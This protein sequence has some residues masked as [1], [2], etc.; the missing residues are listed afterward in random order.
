MKMKQLNRLMLGV[1]LLM[2]LYALAFS[3]GSTGADG[4]F[5]PTVTQQVDL[6]PSGIFNFTNVSIPAGV[7][8]TFKKNA[9]NTP[10]TIL[11]TGDVSIAGT[12]DIS[13]ATS[14][15]VGSNGGSVGDDGQ[16][17]K[18]GPGGFDGGR[19]GKPGV[20]PASSSDTATALLRSGGA[21]LGP[22]GGGLGFLAYSNSTWYAKLGAGGGY[23]ADP[24]AVSQC[25]GD[26]G[27]AYGSTLLLP[28]VGGSGGGGGAGGET[29]YGSG[30]GGGGGA[31]LIA[32]SGTINVTGSLVADG[33]IA[34]E[35][36]G[37]G[38][39]SIGG[40]GAGGA[41]RLVATTV[42]GNGTLY[43][44]GGV[45]PSATVVQGYATPN[46]SYY[47]CYD[48]TLTTQR[49]SAGRIRIEAENLSLTSSPNPTP[50]VGTPGELFVAGLPSLTIA[51]VAGVAAPANPTGNAD[52]S[53]PAETVNPVAV[54]FST[55]GVPV[56]NTVTLTVTPA[57]GTPISAVSP[58]LTGSTASATASV[59]VNLPKGP[60][61]LQAQTT[62]TIVAS[63]GNALSTYANN[64]RVEKVTLTAVAG[65][66][67]KVTLIT[68]S[69]KTF[70][71]SPAQF[72]AVAG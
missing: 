56:G 8:I 11:A 70:D 24:G 65:G 62:Y 48:N 69:G 45:T 22:G 54:V 72:A 37:T 29:Y 20:A 33:G 13:G 27:V 30:G 60:S 61:T 55:T 49:G 47:I 57:Y 52:I 6:P 53:L 59:Q 67:S 19:G 25:H 31:I 10:V 18:G 34:G 12:I 26:G 7:K 2:P 63:L 3:S 66:A 41:I 5:N 15:N 36:S 39:G 35:S 40:G 32:A 28:L 21:G 4:A 46:N 14:P 51:S 64:E 71:I 17:G 9:A 68:A 58:A 38:R 42:S 44:R 23:A 1:G 50:S 16:P 43:A